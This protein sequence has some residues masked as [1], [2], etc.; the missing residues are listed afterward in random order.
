[1][2]NNIKHTTAIEDLLRYEQFM[3]KMYRRHSVNCHDQQT[4]IALERLSASH[5]NQ[6]DALL[7]QLN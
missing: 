7:K 2:E 1:M 6:Y 3:V 5:Q 4:K